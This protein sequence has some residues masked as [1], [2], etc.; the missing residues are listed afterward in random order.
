M[1]GPTVRSGDRKGFAKKPPGYDLAYFA[2]S[3]QKLYLAPPKIDPRSEVS[4]WLAI[5]P[6]FN[7]TR[8]ARAG[9]Y[10]KTR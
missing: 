1:N 8:H 9:M 2:A 7:L 4:D 6:F 3:P 10:C 5:L